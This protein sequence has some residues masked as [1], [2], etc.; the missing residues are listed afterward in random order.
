M[1]AKFHQ[2]LF[3]HCKNLQ[4]NYG[5]IVMII[6]LPFFKI[7]A[8]SLHCQKWVIFLYS[9]QVPKF[10]FGCKQWILPNS[11]SHDIQISS[12]LC[13]S[14]GKILL[15]KLPIYNLKCTKTQEL[16]YQLTATLECIKATGLTLYQSKFDFEKL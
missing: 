9:K 4:N 8:M 11:I 3:I 16:D 12:N 10:F 7:L 1:F 13:N 5:Y 2:S 6:C 14:F 15:N